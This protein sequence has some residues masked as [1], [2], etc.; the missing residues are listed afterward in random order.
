MSQLSGQVN[1]V[2]AGTAVQ[3]PDIKGELFALQA[4]PGNSDVA[5]VGNDGADDVAAAN[6]FPL[7]AAGPGIVV[8]VAE[9]LNELWFDAATNGDD[10]CWIRLTS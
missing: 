7:N 1:V 10:V 8:Q 9:S 4:N 6:G 5:W 3:G 2:T